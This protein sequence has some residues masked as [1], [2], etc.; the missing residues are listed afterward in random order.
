VSSSEKL[1]R[2]TVSGL[3][4]P[5]LERGTVI[6]ASRE[7]TFVTLED[8][9]TSVKFGVFQGEHSLVRDNKKLGEYTIDQLE[10][11]PAGEQAV[12][13]RFTYD[14]NGILEVDMTLVSTGVTETLVIEGSPGRLTADQLAEARAAMSRLK[15]HPRDALPNATL[16][17]RADALH[18]E[19]T[20]DARDE[21]RHALAGFRL[22]LESQD[23]KVVETARELLTQVVN[24]LR[25]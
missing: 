25:R 18:V 15:F 6:P 11:L 19:L 21:L 23:A 1:G 22:A 9:Q 10:P 7:K 16:L 3:F 5:I 2:Q 24:R 4:I 13:V 12:T 20:G 8:N 14:L 17:A